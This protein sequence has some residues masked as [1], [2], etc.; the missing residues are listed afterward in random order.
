MKINLPKGNWTLLGGFPN[1]IQV[2]N[3]K[4]E[5]QATTGTRPNDSDGGVVV[6]SEFGMT[7]AE[8]SDV[9]SNVA[10][11]TQLWA[12]ANQLGVTVSVAHA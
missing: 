4:A 9:F 8:C 5:I 11:A 1:R 12:K 3:G 6:Q 2:L 10:G 7:S